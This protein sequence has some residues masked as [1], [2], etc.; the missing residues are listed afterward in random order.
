MRVLEQSKG[1][2]DLSSGLEPGAPGSSWSLELQA[3]AGAWSLELEPGFK[4][5][6]RDLGL[7]APRPA[8]QTLRPPPPLRGCLLVGCRRGMC[9]CVG[10][11]LPLLYL[12][13]YFI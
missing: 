10:G 6:I 11:S 5:G 7:T 9:V 4:P 8:M 13:L 12:A 3:P 1:L 2:E